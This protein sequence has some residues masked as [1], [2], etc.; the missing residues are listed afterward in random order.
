MPQCIAKSYIRRHEM[1][2]SRQWGCLL[3]AERG[4]DRV[5]T[6][7]TSRVQMYEPLFVA[8]KVLGLTRV[9]ARKGCKQSQR[10]GAEFEGLRFR[11]SNLTI[12]ST[13]VLH[14][15]DKHASSVAHFSAIMLS[16]LSIYIRAFSG[17][18]LAFARRLACISEM[19]PGSRLRPIF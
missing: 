9:G 2:P 18:S 4:E 5:E 10:E 12:S 19:N 1:T 7:E 8:G 14:Y 13:S 3:Y 11:S 17:P 16:I 15:V 6:G